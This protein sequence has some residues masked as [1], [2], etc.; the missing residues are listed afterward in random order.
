MILELLGLLALSLVLGNA[1]LYFYTNSNGQKLN[2]YAAGQAEEWERSIHSLREKDSE[3]ERKILAQEED[4]SRKLNDFGKS[5]S[6]L[7]SKAEHSIG[8]IEKLESLAAGNAAPGE[9]NSMVAGK[10]ERLEDFR[11]DTTIELEAIKD[12][13]PELKKKKAEV[14]DPELEQKIHSLL[15]HGKTSK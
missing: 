6:A 5:L 13:F 14:S 15:F 1:Y 8:R 11:R 4:V 12:L 2:G 9:I 7:D 10:I 3:F